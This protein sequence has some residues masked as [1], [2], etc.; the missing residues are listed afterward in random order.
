MLKEKMRKI[1]VTFALLFLVGQHITPLYSQDFGATFLPSIE[2]QKQELEDNIHK[3]LVNSLKPIIKSNEYLIDIQIE[4]TP[5][6]KPEFNKTDEE[7]ALDAA[8]AESEAK[9]KEEEANKTDEEKAAEAAAKEKK[10][11][12]E[13]KKA[14]DKNKVRLS[15]TDPKDIP[16]DSVLFSKLGLEAPLIDDFNDFQPDGKIILSMAQADP[17]KDNLIESQKA[18]IEKAQ[19]KLDAAKVKEEELRRKLQALNTKPKPSAVEQ[20]WKYNE[21][22][23]IFK[24]LKSVKIKVQLNEELAQDT[25]DTIS[26]VLNSINFNLGKVKPQLTIEYVNMKEKFKSDV[27]P[28]KL[29]DIIDYASKFS[30]AL[31]LLLSALLL[32]LVAFV[33][34]RMYKSLK[35]NEQ[36]QQAAG[37]AGGPGAAEAA[38]DDEDEDEMGGAFSMGGEDMQGGLNGIERFRTFLSKNETEASMLIKKWIKSAEKDEQNA[39]RAVVQQLDNS[40]LVKIFEQLSPDERSEWKKYLDKSV[41][42]EGLKRANLFISTQIVEEIIV[43]AAITDPEAQD[44]LLKIKPE[45][46]AKFVQEN[47]DLG[48][49]LMNVMNT[50]F[51]SKIIDNLESSYIDN[52]IDSSIDF[53]SSDIETQLDNFKS[54][55]AEYQ[56]EKKRIPFL[57]RVQELIPIASPSRENSLFK[58]LAKSG[59]QEAMYKLASQFFP[60]V[61]VPELPVNFLKTILQQYPMGPKIEM[62]L[63]IDETLK[64]HFV[65]IFAPE[66]SKAN[67]MLQLEFEKAE[68]DISVQRRVRNEGEEIWKEFVDFSRRQIKSDKTVAGDI[69]SMVSEWVEKVCKGQSPE[70]AAHSLES[71]GSKVAA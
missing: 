34:F 52:I 64:D 13:K 67:D 42:G 9:K 18:K 70:Q 71:S 5:P 68:N 20:L 2:W 3:K 17:E 1:V 10:A 46:A 57:E 44:L 7:A 60:A 49:I 25:R 61:L 43:P 55:L 21:S 59:D 12:E 30:V 45:Q 23:D 8:V 39:L 15:D 4:A 27:L 11:Q 32:A 53:D 28:T 6:E 16:E 36:P 51:V 69:D 26:N 31:G 62:L 50:K 41:D 22:V 65:G 47:P 24:N 56:D 54:K 63:S 19:E 35:E 37:G 14:E 48:K 38:K 66:G 33:I 29:K 40:E 58:A